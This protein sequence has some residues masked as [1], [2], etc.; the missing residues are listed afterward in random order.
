MRTSKARI[1]A[2]LVGLMALAVGCLPAVDGAVSG[3]NVAANGVANSP[4]AL[5]IEET[6]AAQGIVG[7]LGELTE[8]ARQDLAKRLEMP[9]D[10][11]IVFSAEPVEW[12]DGSLGCPKPGIIYPQVITPGYLIILEADGKRYEYHSDTV[13]QVILCAQGMKPA[14]PATTPGSTEGV[15]HRAKSDLAQRLGLASAGIDVVRVTRVELPIQDLGCPGSKEPEFTIP[16][17]VTGYEIILS[18]GGKEHVYH[19]RGARVVFCQ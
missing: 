5:P 2:I 6:P 16:A 8:L 3:G 11:I 10:R 1:P 9:L 19:A 4:L 15:V 17:L 13:K 7:E 18:A 12:A 14:L